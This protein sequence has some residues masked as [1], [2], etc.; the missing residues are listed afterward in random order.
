MN[1]ETN[2]ET[3]E[4][5]IPMD[6]THEAGASE[7]DAGVEYLWGM[8]MRWDTEQAFK[9]FWNKEDDRI[10]PPKYFGIG[11]DLNFHALAKK[12]KKSLDDA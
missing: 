2:T 9:N 10:L 12:M 3:P 1:Q 11:W 4:N 8:P 5:E 6:E 7:R